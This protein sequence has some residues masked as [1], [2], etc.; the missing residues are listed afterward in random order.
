MSDSKLPR[1][2]VIAEAANPQ[3]TSVALIGYS[4]TRALLDVADVQLATELR[5][6]DSILEA[7]FP[8]ERLIPVD[9]RRM[10]GMAFKVA[11]FLRGGESLGW[12]IYSAFYNVAY[13]VFERKLWRQLEGPLKA[14]E[15]DLVHRVTPLSPT[16]ASPIAKRLQKIGVPLII[17]PLNG[18]VPWPVG[19]DAIRRQE[20]EWLSYVRG[21]YRFTPDLQGTRDRAAALLLASGHTYGEVVTTGER[22][23]KAIYVPENAID[24]ERFPMPDKDRPASDVLRLAFVGRLVP[25][26]GAVTLL[27]AALPLLKKRCATLDIIGD[28]AEMGRL[29]ELVAE[30][31]LEQV[32]TLPGWIAHEKLHAR[33]READVFAFPSVREFGG[34]V[35]LEAMALG[36]APVVADYAGPTELVPDDCGWRVPFDSVETLREGFTQKLTELA[37]QPALVRE[38]GARAC[39]FVRAHFTWQAKA[40]QIRGVYDW[41]LGRRERPEF[42]FAFNPEEMQA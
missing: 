8:A 18:G 38:T 39:D 42:A 1:V 41:A 5:N 12:T 26:K 28:G 11:K 2:L 3:L 40:Q 13:P 37:A 14:R 9:N 27:E 30:N 19:F 33:L 16:T 10:Q 20:R 17:G 35:V 34:G 29:K 4:L 31:E 36:L 22:R 15:F 6:K 32:V 24:P 7:G 25:Y 23:R 21:L